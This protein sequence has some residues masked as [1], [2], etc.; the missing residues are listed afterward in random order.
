M[1]VQKLMKCQM[2]L[3]IVPLSYA[4]YVYR[5]LLM[6]FA[7]LTYAFI[8]VLFRLLEMFGCKSIFVLL[9]YAYLHV[10]LCKFVCACVLLKI[11]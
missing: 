11:C 1:H 6:H 10:Y 5:R 2:Q 9:T 4:F 3:C 7:V 8:H